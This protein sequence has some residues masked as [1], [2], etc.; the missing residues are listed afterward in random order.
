MRRVILIF[1]ILLM[2]ACYAAFTAGWKANELF[3]SRETVNSDVE[4]TLTSQ[5]QEKLSP[6]DWVKEEQIKVYSDKIVLEIPDAKW[7]KFSDT[8]SMDPL[9]DVDAN[10]LQ[11]V[12]KNN[13]DVHTGDI[14]SYETSQGTIIHRVVELGYDG[15]WYAITKGDNN[16][17]NDPEKVRFSQVKKIVVGVIY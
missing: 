11:I 13:A 8:N 9:F 10:V 12:P 14:I 7:A 15:D 3:N 16:Q 17:Q 1:A 5:A 2:L 4:R 6:Y